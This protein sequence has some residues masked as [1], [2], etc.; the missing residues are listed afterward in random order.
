[1]KKFKDQPPHLLIPKLV[2]SNPITPGT[3][4][5]KYILTNGLAKNNLLKTL[6]F[7][8]TRANGRSFTSGHI[9]IRGRGAGAKK[10]YRKLSF[11]NQ[12]SLGIILFSTY[13]PN[14]T[15]F[16]SAVFDFL[17]YSFF[18][19]PTIVNQFVGLIVGC[20]KPNHRFYFGFRYKLID[21]KNGSLLSFLALPNKTAQIAKSAGTCCLL[22]KSTFTCKIR[23]PSNQII[24]VSPISFATLGV[25]S[26][27]YHRFI[28]IG[29][30]GRNRLKNFRP[31]VRGIA[32][33]AVD[34]PHGGQT[35]GGCCWV[36]PWGKPFRFKKTSRSKRK[37]IFKLL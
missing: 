25:V 13:D 28:V 12:S 7:K 35:N 27:P 5:K 11:L 33:N 22:L 14:R 24:I 36:T 1:M 6:I 19:I 26:N 15:A 23:L 37:K 16:I 30:A 2:T 8:I 32:M 10:L 3:R 9:T 21:H 18:F 31:K 4:H 20:K 34:H 17:K 29:K